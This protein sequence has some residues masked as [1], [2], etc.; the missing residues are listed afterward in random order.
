MPH[1]IFSDR[2]K[3]N[4]VNFAGPGDELI[5]ESGREVEPMKMLIARLRRRDG[6]TVRLERKEDY[7]GDRF[8]IDPEC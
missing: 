3:I 4:L 8:V 1:L 6:L 2:Q 5:V 7:D